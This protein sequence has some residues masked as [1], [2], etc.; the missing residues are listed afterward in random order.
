MIT[1][2]RIGEDLADAI[3]IRVD[4][5][6]VLGNPFTL[7]TESNRDR[8]CDR[9]EKYFIDK[10]DSVNPQSKEIRRIISLID[11]GHDINLQ[12]WCSPKRCHA[13]T[14]KEFLDALYK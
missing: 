2:G 11:R 5:S 13:E 9:Y 3:N 8:V 14:I 7:N 1:I 12:C 4:R 10:L 6:S